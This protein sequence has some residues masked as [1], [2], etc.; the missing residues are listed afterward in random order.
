MISNRN[1]H[2][3]MGFCRSLFWIWNYWM[4]HLWVSVMQMDKGLKYVLSQGTD[5]TSWKEASVHCRNLVLASSW[6]A[7]E[8]VWNYVQPGQVQS[9]TLSTFPTT[10]WEPPPKAGI[11][12]SGA[13][14]SSCAVAEPWHAAAEN[15]TSLL[16]RMSGSQVWKMHSSPFT[17]THHNVQPQKG[18]RS[19]QNN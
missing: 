9:T 16:S 14:G 12:G 3:R 10:G 4:L 6:K 19:H 8:M 13:E 15:S 17:L 1:K 2:Y 7:G 11:L 18:E 5:G